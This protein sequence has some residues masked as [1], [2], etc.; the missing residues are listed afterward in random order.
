MLKLQVYDDGELVHSEEWEGPVALGRASDAEPL[1]RRVNAEGEWR[2]PIAAFA[3]KEMSRRHA[4]VEPT[5]ASLRVTNLSQGRSITI[6]SEDRGVSEQIGAKKSRQGL[7]L[8]L[9]IRLGRSPTVVRVS[10]ADEVTFRPLCGER[11][12]IGVCGDPIPS[13]TVD[14]VGFSGSGIDSSIR[15]LQSVANLLRLA[16][17]SQDFFAPVAQAVVEI[18]GIYVLDSSCSIP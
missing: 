3:D 10:E 8:P 4:L 11:M 16:M 17:T 5:G 1:F 7:A 12:T 13:A 6:E 2:L 14:P 15:A 9:L 18:I